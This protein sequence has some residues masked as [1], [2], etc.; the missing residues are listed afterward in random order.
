[1]TEQ[2]QVPPFHDAVPCVEPDEGPRLLANVVGCPPESVRI[3]MPVRLE[4][5]GEADGL[6][7]PVFVPA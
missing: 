5:R 1:M 2:N 6:P 3:G 7:H 4:F